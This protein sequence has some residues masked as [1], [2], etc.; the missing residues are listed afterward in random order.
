MEDQVFIQR[1]FKIEKNGISLSDALILPKN[2]YD[3]LSE[4]DIES[5]KTERFTNHKERLE[6]P[7]VVEAPSDE[8]VLADIDAQLVELQKH[9]L[10]VASRVENKPEENASIEFHKGGA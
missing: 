6:N 8:Q 5:L 2:E 4:Q 3:S 9:R 1:R 10:E 7:P